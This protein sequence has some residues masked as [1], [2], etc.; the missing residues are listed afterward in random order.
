[1]GNALTTQVLTITSDSIGYTM[2]GITAV[3][4]LLVSLMNLGRWPRKK[5]YSIVITAAV[6]GN[7]LAIL[8]VSILKQQGGEINY[9]SKPGALGGF[10]I[11]AVAIV[12]IATGIQGYPVLGDENEQ[13]REKV[14]KWREKRGI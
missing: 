5:W 4:T 3:V 14:K 12:E 13:Q 7:L 9:D 6:V 1:M 8:G 2:L 11:A 10:G